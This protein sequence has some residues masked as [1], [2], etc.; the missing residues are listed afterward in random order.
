M[1]N[2]IQL[3]KNLTGFTENFEKKRKFPMICFCFPSFNINHYL[4]S[5]FLEPYNII[6]TMLFHVIRSKYILTMYECTQ[7]K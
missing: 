3:V 5:T 7:I 6:L 4:K 1:Y 2:S